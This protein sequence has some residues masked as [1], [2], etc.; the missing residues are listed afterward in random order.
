MKLVLYLRF[1]I[2]INSICIELKIKNK[3]IEKN[4]AEYVSDLRDRKV[5]SKQSQRK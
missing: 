5:F 4:N 3:T 1:H 2:R